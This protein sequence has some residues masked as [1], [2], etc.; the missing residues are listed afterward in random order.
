MCV[1]R[2]KR[3]L[4]YCFYP[5]Y[6]YPTNVIEVFISLFFWWGNQGSER[7]KLVGDGTKIHALF[8]LSR[9]PPSLPC[10][11]QLLTLQQPVAS[12]LFPASSLS[13]LI[14]KLKWYYFSR[15]THLPGSV[16]RWVVSNTSLPWLFLSP[17]RVTLDTC[18]RSSGPQCLSLSK[19]KNYP[20]PSELEKGL[21]QLPCT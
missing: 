7:S 15:I 1:Q 17:L 12:D 14:W 16:S 4:F 18:I 13:S 20:Y 2:S 21:S 8:G 3:K 11:A 19:K 10:V 5:S 9:E 6:C